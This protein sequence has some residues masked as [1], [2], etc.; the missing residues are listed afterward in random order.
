MNS[1]AVRKQAYVDACVLIAAFQGDHDLSSKALAVLDD[2]DLDIVVSDYVRL[3]VLPKP[4]FHENKAE[5]EFMEE[6]FNAASDVISSDEGITRDAVTLAG[7]YDLS[8]VDALHVSCAIHAAVDELVTVEKPTKPMFS[9]TEV[10]VK[11][12]RDA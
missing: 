2:P 7:R 9:V 4:T 5:V 12:L 8:P 10:D 3:E 6:V 1:S 11:S